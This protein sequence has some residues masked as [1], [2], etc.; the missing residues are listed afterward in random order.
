MRTRARRP[1]VAGLFYEASKEGL[2]KQLAEAFTHP[3]GPGEEPPPP[4][5]YSGR[6]VG[7]VAPH[8]G[9]TY[10]G[11]VAAHG[12][13]ELAR[14]GKPESVVL[15]GPNHHAWGMPVAVSEADEWLTPL[16]SLEVD[17][18]LAKAIVEASDLIVF[19]EEA[20]RYEHSIEVQLPFLQ[21]VFGEGV[22]IVPISMYLQNLEVSRR[23]GDAIARAFKEL[24]V[25]AYVVA[26]SDFTHYEEARK[27]R[28]KDEAA[29]ERILVLDDR[30]L[31]NVVIERDATICGY[32]A[33]MTL[34]AVTRRLG[35]G[36]VKLLKYANSGDVTGD[37]SSVVGYAAI[38]FYRRLTA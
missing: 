12:Y 36:E 25:K 7:I 13:L 34:I 15:I 28:E 14:G 37:Y 30:G 2:L 26:S 11:H 38:A 16:G 33:I 29:I 9:Y 27:A 20:H 6:V 1:V 19:D 5:S 24:D 32:G 17:K 8:A 23:L 35:A 3:L 31:Y 22:R 4:S 10:S 18:E 21:Y